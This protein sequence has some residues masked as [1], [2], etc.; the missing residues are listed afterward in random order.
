MRYSLGLLPALLCG[1]ALY[2]G[3][4]FTMLRFH[5]GLY[6]ALLASGVMGGVG[7]ELYK[8]GQAYMLLGWSEARLMYLFSASGSPFFPGATIG[9]A[10][11]IE[12]PFRQKYYLQGGIGMDGYILHFRDGGGTSLQDRQLRPIL[13]FE[14]GSFAF[15]DGIFLRYS[16]YPLPGTTGK[17]VFTI[18]SYLGE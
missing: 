13:T 4:E 16:F 15:A 3:S 5:R 9:T 10:L 6:P 8:S 11:R 1:Q 12:L 2:I 14:C 17:F 18:G 7:W